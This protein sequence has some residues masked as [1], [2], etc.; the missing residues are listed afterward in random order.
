MRQE[1]TGR[2]QRQPRDGTV[3]GMEI[4]CVIVD[5]SEQFRFSARR[6][7]SAQGISVLA[8][9]ADSRQALRV[10]DE[11]HPDVVLVDVHLGVENGFDLA[12]RVRSSIVIMMSASVTPDEVEH[13]MPHS[14]A[15]GFLPKNELSADAIKRILSQ[16]DRG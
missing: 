9:A 14:P 8:D 13:L 16:R 2:T 3:E 15:I 5:D 4:R 7:L 6:L 12:E 1:P 11:R 10:V